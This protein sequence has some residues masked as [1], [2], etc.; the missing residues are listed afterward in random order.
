MDSVNEAFETVD[1]AS[2]ET[3]SRSL[4]P[5]EHPL[6]MP[7]QNL[8]SWDAKPS[9]AERI[10]RKR[11]LAARLFVFTAATLSTGYGVWE[12]VEI[13]GQYDAT[14]LQLVLVV[15]FAFTFFWIALAAS[16][17]LLGFLAIAC[18]LNARRTYSGTRELSSRTAVVMPVFNENTTRVFPSLGRMADELV[19]AGAGTD[20]DFFVLSDSTELGIALDERDAAI[21]LRHSF[22]GR[23]SIYYRRRALN[24]EHKA[25]NIADFV[26]RWGGAY[27]FMIVLDA[28]SYM[29]AEAMI[30]LAKAM[31]ADP[32]AALI[33]T[34]PRLANHCTLFARLQQFATSIYSPIITAGLAL[35]HGR[36]GNYWGHNAIIRIRAFAGACG[37]PKLAG[38]RPF[39]GNIMSHDFVE[40]A[41]LRRAGFDVYMR[42]D[43]GGS[44]EEAPPTLEAHARRDRR[45]VQG[46]LQHIRVVP[47][48]GLHWMSRFHLING[49]MSYVASPLWLAFLITGVV[50]AWQAGLHQPNYFPEEH[51]LFPTW[52]RFDA[53]RAWAL[54]G[55]T[56]AVLL[57]PKVFGTLIALF[58]STKRRW[59]GGAHALLGSVLYE[60]AMSTLL[61][62]VLMLLQTRFI[63]DT[64]LG[65]DSGWGAQQRDEITGTSIATK[66]L[67]HTLA[68]L[69]LLGATL[70]VSPEL[71]LWLLPVWLGLSVSIPLV[72]LT[73]SRSA[74]KFTRGLGLLLIAEEHE[75][76]VKNSASSRDLATE[77]WRPDKKSP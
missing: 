37:L 69:V 72:H 18:K 67:G 33:Q 58:D 73:S 17:A 34:A 35:W 63:L 28:D 39:D 10:D 13:V 19:G 74:G 77:Q 55:F 31:E 61:A 32:H 14:T 3:I 25:G 42:P 11:T 65:R 48:A 49:I 2:S 44:Y 45:W 51:A 27:D 68:G 16:N 46:N 36:D 75:E 30:K 71:S 23:L 53:E 20:F 40:A 12:M 4:V 21:E 24:E 1:A 62:P 54:L 52:P 60:T 66:H 8:T 9:D 29:T 50:L 70:M 47:A 56:L 7:E 26:R 57:A 6:E 64:L 76:A 38:R 22:L 15:L 5:A 59:A 41:L 43:I